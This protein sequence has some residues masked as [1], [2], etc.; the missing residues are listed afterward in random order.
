MK[1]LFPLMVEII[2]RKFPSM[3]EERGESEIIHITT[4]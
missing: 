3:D 4:I 2:G 1:T